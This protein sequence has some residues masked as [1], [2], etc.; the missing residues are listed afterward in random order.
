[1]TRDGWSFDSM[2]AP[3][4]STRMIPAMARFERRRVVLAAAAACLLL[5]SSPHPMAAAESDLDAFMRQVMAR[6]DDNWK[7]LQQYVLDERERMDLHGPAH[8]PLWGET[9]EYA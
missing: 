9:R 2:N 3:C 4:G 5:A 1:M 6:R 8:V 7:K